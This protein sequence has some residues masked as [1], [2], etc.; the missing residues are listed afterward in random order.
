MEHCELCA[1]NDLEQRAP[2]FREFACKDGSRVL[3][4]I[5]LFHENARRR[6][7]IFRQREARSLD[8]DAML[9]VDPQTGHTAAYA[10]Q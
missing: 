2:F 10:V 7:V 6:L 9:E 3:K 4:W 1:M 8:R 5:C